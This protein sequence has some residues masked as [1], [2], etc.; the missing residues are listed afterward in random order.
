M[1]QLNVYI[2]FNGNCREA[3]EFYQKCLGGSLNLSTFAGSPLESQVPANMKD[4]IAHSRLEANGMIIAAD[5]MMRP[6]V[7]TVGNNISLLVQSVSLKEIE[8]YFS[9]L[10]EGGKVVQPLTKA[11][12]GTF[13]II[14]DK[15]GISWVF[16]AD[17]P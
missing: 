9:R 15:F 17:K 5:D 14:N 3:M 10:A 12:F 13:G 4:K 11:F 7:V 6:G 2:H 16:Q 1:P 8:P